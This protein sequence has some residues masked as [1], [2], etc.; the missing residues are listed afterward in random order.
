MS[1]RALATAASLSRYSAM[2]AIVHRPQAVH[3]SL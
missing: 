2:S 1:S 3:I